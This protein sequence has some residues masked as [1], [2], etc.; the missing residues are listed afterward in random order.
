MSTHMN[1]LNLVSATKYAYMDL[2]TST[3]SEHDVNDFG[4]GDD[5]EYCPLSPSWHILMFA[6]F[7]LMLFLAL[8]ALY[9][10]ACELNYAT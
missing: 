6:R 2:T 5:V 10:Y 9:E 3:F 4:S 8:S 7:M 1:Q